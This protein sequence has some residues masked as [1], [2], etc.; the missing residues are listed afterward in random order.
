MSTWFSCADLPLLTH[1]IV[2]AEDPLFLTAP[3]KACS[4]ID[5]MVAAITLRSDPR[6]SP[7]FSYAARLAISNIYIKPSRLWFALIAV[8][9]AQSKKPQESLD[10]ILNKSYLGAGV[11]GEPI[12]GFQQAAQ[13]YFKCNLDEL[14]VSQAAMLAGMIRA[15]SRYNPKK[16]PTLT[17]AR[18]NMI[19][20]QMQKSGFI[21]ESEATTARHER[22]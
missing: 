11:E 20:D 4:L 10:L 6:C 17:K 16:D 14:K 12:E 21:S 22:L 18:R 15:P 5:L 19:I 13:F 3:G 8:G 7:I 2:A 1:A 9:E